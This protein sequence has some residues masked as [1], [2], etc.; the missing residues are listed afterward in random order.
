M[1]IC[2]ILDKQRVKI[3]QQTAVQLEETKK[4]SVVAPAVRYEW[5]KKCVDAIHLTDPEN[6]FLNNDI[7]STILKPLTAEARILQPP[8]I[9]YGNDGKVPENC[10]LVKG[11]REFMVPAALSKWAVYM[12][13]EKR[14]PALEEDLRTFIQRL[15]RTANSF[16]MKV[17]LPM[18]E[19]II[20][21]DKFVLEE[22]VRVA[23][24][25][26]CTFIFFI[27]ANTSYLHDA[28]KLF[29]RKYEIITQDMKYSTFND[30]VWKN[31][32]ALLT[33]LVSKLN[34]KL[35]GINYSIVI[36]E[37]R[38]RH[39]LNDKR[40]I[41]GFA[42]IYPDIL[43]S[44]ETT[45]SSTSFPFVAGCS[46]NAKGFPY[47]FIGD[48]GFQ[49]ARQTDKVS[50]FYIFI[51]RIT[52][53]FLESRRS[54]PLEVLIYCS[55]ISEGRYDLILNYEMPVI[56]KAL[57]DGGCNNTVKVTFIVVNRKH[58]IRLIPK[59]LD[60]SAN[61]VEQNCKSGTVFDK[62]IVH[63]RFNEFYLNSHKTIQGTARV[64]CYTVVVDDSGY[65]LDELEL[66]TYSLCHCHQIANLCT[67][68]PSPLFIAMRY[69][70]RGYHVLMKYNLD[71]CSG[72]SL[73]VKSKDPLDLQNANKILPYY[74]SLLGE[75]RIN[76]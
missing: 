43:E 55:G 46:S 12:L 33:N 76:A 27:Q 48:F 64:P 7:L 44:G 20:P 50:L 25:N 57:I 16:D 69:A 39:I 53:R 63:P 62:H 72:S 37:E 67:S 35:G 29:E 3:Q 32:R 19:E 22:V 71:V 47:E 58:N 61:I 49:D 30:I 17:S 68:I 60:P 1:E 10:G 8:L 26:G 56:R 13:A 11:R 18:N 54:P 14:S 51:K 75:K 15:V 73:N 34:V 31:K 9:V 24:N 2:Y 59:E 6:K 74:G 4:V 21:S 66:A 23:K 52:K 45:K 41:I 28:I 38:Y 36:P 42:M 65:S 40:L 70:E 5:S